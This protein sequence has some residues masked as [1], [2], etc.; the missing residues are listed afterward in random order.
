MPL[1]SPESW[2]ASRREE[3]ILLFMVYRLSDA[4]FLGHGDGLL[5]TLDDGGVNHLAVEGDGAAALLVGQ[6]DGVHDL[7]C[8]VN[9]LMGGAEH[10]VDHTH[11]TGGDGGLAG[12]VVVDGGGAVAVDL[13]GLAH[14]VDG[15]ALVAAGATR[16]GASSGKSIVE[17]K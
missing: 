14:G 15:H 9:V 13:L 4:H 6:T 3:T 12:K 16:I 17:E 2:M 7:V 1:F 5:G 11:V 10:L 8:V